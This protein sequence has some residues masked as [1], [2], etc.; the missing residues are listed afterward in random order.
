MIKTL[1][2]K[3]VSS[4]LKDQDFKTGA[5]AAVNYFLLQQEPQKQIELCLDH[6]EI[7]QNFIITGM[8]GS[9]KKNGILNLI[10][11][12]YP[13]PAA[14]TEYYY[15]PEKNTI[16]TEAIGSRI[17]AQ[18]KNQVILFESNPNITSLSGI[19]SENSYKPGSLVKS[20]GGYLVMPILPFIQDL[21]LFNFL[22]N[23]LDRGRIDFSSFP[24]L[25][26]F[27]GSSRSFPDIPLQTRVILFGDEEYYDALLKKYPKLTNIF[28]MRIELA[29]DA[30]ISRK[31]LLAFSELID[32]WKKNN[33]PA[34]APSAKRKLMEYTL[35]GYDSKHRFPLKLSD[36]RD[37]YEEAQVLFSAKKEITDRDISLAVANLISRNSSGKIRYLEE[38]K[39]GFIKLHLSGS[40]IGRIN[41][42]SIITFFNP[43]IDYG[44]VNVVSARIS[45]GT[46][47]VLN[48]ERESNLSG[49]IYDRA[50]FTLSSYIKGLF[51]HSFDLDI[52]IMFE[53]NHI[54][55][56]GDSASAAELL[57]VLSALGEQP[58]QSH[59]A[60]T[61]SVTQYGDILPVGAINKKIETWHE[62]TSLFG[63]KSDTYMLFVPEAN[64]RD[65]ILPENVIQSVKSGKLVLKSYS[66]INDIIP[67]IMGIEAGKK[68]KNGH[69]NEN[70]LLGKIESRLESKKT[71]NNNEKE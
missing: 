30:Y 68:N 62:I 58:I 59:I 27:Q 55:I 70:T 9:G 28:K 54:M 16:S 61:G 38:I 66:H 43:L 10:R 18:P 17:I 2:S 69:Y 13:K 21:H 32:T 50:I 52:S 44:Q 65:I 12:K 45:T 22:L 23:C 33:Y 60:V 14:I 31:S 51:Q 40:R 63:K 6:P 26:F 36:T 8:Q 4:H 35:A 53:Q 49:D 11:D 56:D 41:A 34:A 5:K 37:I 15:N 25:P 29:Y 46:G 47:N 48:V 20:S 39:D 1:T 19:C 64:S 7:Y 24:E 57:A 3:D 42:L 67:E 71:E